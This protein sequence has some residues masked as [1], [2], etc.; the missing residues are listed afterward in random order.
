MTFKVKGEDGKVR[1]HT[2]S[3]TIEGVNVTFKSVDK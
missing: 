2:M 3:I 1:S